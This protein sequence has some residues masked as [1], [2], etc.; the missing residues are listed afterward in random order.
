MNIWALAG[1][2]QLVGARHPQ[3]RHRL[4]IPMRQ[5]FHRLTGHDRRRHNGHGRNSAVTIALAARNVVQSRCS[6]KSVAG[7]RK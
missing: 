3:K 5:S 6:G 2:W 1:S 4:G 7:R